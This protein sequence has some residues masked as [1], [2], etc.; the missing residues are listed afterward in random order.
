MFKD[1]RDFLDYL[2]RNGKLL[3][4]QKEVDTHFDIAAGIRKVS[5][6]DGPALLFERIK[7]FPDWRVAGGL[8]ATQKLFSAA[9]G[10]PF[11]AD[12]QSI[13]KRYFECDQ[14][15]VKP[16]LISTGPVKEVILKGED[17]DLNKL[18]VVTYSGLDA[19]PYLTGGVDIG[20][21]HR[22][23]AQ[24]AS[25][26]R[27]QILGK[28]RTAILARGYQHLGRLILAAEAD[29]QGLQ[30]ATV[31]GAPPELT[32]ASQ[33]EAPADVDE[34][35]IAGAFRGAPIEM[36]KCE[37]I[38]VEVPASAEIVIEGVTLPKE[39]TIDGPFGEF[40][41]N[42][43]SLLGE[44]QIEVPVIEVTAITMRKDPIFQAVLTGMP[45][46]EN[47]YLKKWA[48]T[49]AAFREI[50]GIA[51]I[52]AINCTQGGVAGYHLVVAIHKKDDSEPRR[53]ID[54][55]INSRRAPK[56]TVIVDDDI[57]VYD[58]VDVEWAVATRMKADEDVIII[59]EVSNTEVPV[60]L[61]PRWPKLAID[62]T[63]PLRDKKWYQ[64]IHIPGVDKVDY[65]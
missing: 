38:D 11:E 17:I 64:K 20:R 62:A 2:E 54:A 63:A 60:T 46:T 15:R 45:M 30:I 41:G 25:M 4:I 8:F 13:T 58:P 35:Y 50:N 16:K 31:I 57:D 29:G 59:P 33:M 53:L 39:R 56:Y 55:L 5:D 37:T 52:R 48:L 51:D 65:V 32:I 10:L 6:T 26:H 14:E 27:R 47:H 34:T 43:I 22:T 49:A 1:F 42:Y 36:V 12:E 7:G 3:K 28:N 19:G 24:N 44:P 21:S 9:L 61:G 23:G 18:P 40:P